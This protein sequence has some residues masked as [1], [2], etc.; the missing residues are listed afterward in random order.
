VDPFAQK[1]S[2]VY[3]RLKA[4]EAKSKPI[5]IAE[6]GC[7]DSS[8]AQINAADWANQA[9]T[10]MVQG[11]VND[12]PDL[13][14]FSWWNERWRNDWQSPVHDPNKDSNMLVQENAAL[15]SVFRQRLANSM[16]DDS[17]RFRS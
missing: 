14:G 15:A 17:L 8:K 13:I 2:I 10:A 5:V 9:L 12:W 11:A 1:I 16:I 4:S 6:F 3:D 7:V